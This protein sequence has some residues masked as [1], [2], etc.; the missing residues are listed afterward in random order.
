[1]KRVLV[2]AAMLLALAAFPLSALAATPVQDNGNMFSS[3]AKNQATQI[4]N[5]LQRQT[6]KEVVVYTVPSLNG[7]DPSA[8]ADSIFRAQNVNGVLLFM[9]SQDRRLEIKVGQDTRQALSTQREAQ[10]RDTI[11]SDFRSNKFDQGLLDGV[12]GVRSALAS[13]PASSR[14]APVRQS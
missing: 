10:I 11:L 6:G 3:G 9:S 4:I 2:L 12:N 7:Q 14:G 5:T 13:A 1:M 8:A